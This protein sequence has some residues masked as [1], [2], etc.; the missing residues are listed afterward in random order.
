MKTL[1]FHDAFLTRGWAEHMNLEIANILSADIATAIWSDFTYI[2]EQM[3]YHGKIHE[4]YPEYKKWLLWFLKMK[5]KFYNC[6]EI[7]QKYDTV[8][9]SNETITAI[10]GLWEWV[11]SVYYAYSLSRHFFD[12]RKE[13]KKTLHPWLRW[14]FEVG[15]FIYRQ[16]YVYELKKV[17]LIITNSTQNK[18]ILEKWT[19]R[20]D[21]QVLH[22]P[23]NTLRYH[24]P[25]VK[26]PFEFEEHNNMQSIISKEIPEYYISFSQLSEAKRVKSIIHAFVHMPEKNLVVL[27]GE[28]DSQKNECMQVAR[29][30]NNIFFH[31]NVDDF[32][33]PEYIGWAI[34]SISI[35][36]NEDFWMVAIESMACGIPV[37][38]VNEWW[39]KESIIHEK[40]GILLKPEFWVYDLIEAINEMTPEK[41]AS[42]KWDCVSR[43]ANFSLDTFAVK[44]KEYF[45]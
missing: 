27:F 41:A 33:L 39:Y 14:L 28:Y 3:G 7:T 30:A 25:K 26:K 34:A 17:N 19:K 11:Q 18:E 24:P 10:H 40:T 43:A 8:I 20:K 4:L 23:V 12:Q 45:I 16:I 44:L 38:S 13:F 2:P 1:L 6:E 29:G 22:P 31:E 42:M 5:W 36:R 21:I 37:I 9:L 32:I 15:A 35:G